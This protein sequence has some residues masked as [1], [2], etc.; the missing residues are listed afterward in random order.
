VKRWL[1]RR[2]QIL[3]A[4]TRGKRKLAIDRDGCSLGPS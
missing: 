2:L 4:Q 3:L 1:L